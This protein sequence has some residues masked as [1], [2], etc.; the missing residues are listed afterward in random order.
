MMII[1]IIITIIIII[2]ITIIIIVNL[3]TL[4]ASKV[5]KIVHKITHTPAQNII[6]SY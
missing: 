3:H 1:I 2:I 6:Y 5:L 4:Q